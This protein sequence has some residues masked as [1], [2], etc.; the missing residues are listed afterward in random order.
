MPNE[1]ILVFNLVIDEF[2]NYFSDFIC[3]V[4]VILINYF[5]VIVDAF[6][7][8]VLLVPSA[9]HKSDVLWKIFRVELKRKDSFVIWNKHFI[10]ARMTKSNT[11][12]IVRNCN[13]IVRM[14]LVWL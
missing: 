1:S 6:E 5:L 10:A 7:V 11:S 8:I 13:H 14:E 3:S 9:L 12:K 2:S 4:M